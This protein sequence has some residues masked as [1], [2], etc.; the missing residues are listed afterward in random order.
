MVFFGSDD[1]ENEAIGEFC[2]YLITDYMFDVIYYIDYMG[3][4]A[5]KPF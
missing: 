1:E 2:L 3:I 4:L 5:I